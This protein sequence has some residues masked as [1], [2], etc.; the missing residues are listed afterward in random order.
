MKIPYVVGLG[1][2][3]AGTSA[4]AQSPQPPFPQAQIDKG[5][6]VYATYCVPCHG[7]AMDY[8]GGS[9]DLRTFPPEQ[10][11]RFAN[12][13]TKGKNNMPPWGDMLQGGDIEALWAYVM[14]GE[15]RK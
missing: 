15:G 4:G 7:V 9:F 2:V 10:F 3:L 1:L 6:E 11:A 14:G 5:A 13:V 8:P 12:S